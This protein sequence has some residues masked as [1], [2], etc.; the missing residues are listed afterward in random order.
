M[1]FIAEQ[2]HHGGVDQLEK[3]LDLTELLR[4][5]KLSNM[6]F[7]GMFLPHLVQTYHNDHPRALDALA[8][9]TSV[10]SSEFSVRPFLHHAPKELIPVLEKWSKSPDFHIRRLASEGSRPLLPWAM[11]LPH[12]RKEPTLLAPLL[13]RLLEDPVE[14]VSRSA[15]NHFND[16][17]KDHPDWVAEQLKAAELRKV[18]K[19]TTLRHA[20]RTLIKQAHQPTMDLFGLAPLSCELVVQEIDSSEVTI[21]SSLFYK[22]KLQIN[23]TGTLRL[24]YALY[25][26][27]A[28]GHQSRKQFHWL[29]RE[30][31]QSQTLVLEKAIWLK[32]LTTR[33]LYPGAHAVA[34]VANGVEFPK[35]KFSLKT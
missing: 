22:I 28:N 34:L 7:L 23:Q 2:L 8:Q 11:Q 13:H 4:S 31:S 25:F 24:A 10:A 29:E 6:S 26:T 19:V 3:V 5:E 32:P 21:G 1:N 12:Y 16:I 33:K 18:A 14:Y 20:A 9:I 27:K 30:I 35:L 15:S 17:S